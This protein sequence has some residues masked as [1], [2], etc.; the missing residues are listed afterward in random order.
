MRKSQE[1]GRGFVNGMHQFRSLLRC[2]K[3]APV[4]KEGG[5]DRSKADFVWCLMAAQRGHSIEDIAAR[6]LEVSSKAQ[7]TSRRH[8]EGYALVTAENASSAAEKGRKRGSG[9]ISYFSQSGIFSGRQ[10]RYNPA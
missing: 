5:P 10:I 9:Q 8:H 2:V 4:A 7:E 6:L 3:G 1:S